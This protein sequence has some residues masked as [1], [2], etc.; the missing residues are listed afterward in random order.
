MNEITMKRIEER[1]ET[2]LE[3]G[4][5]TKC[6]RCD[7]NNAEIIKT[8]HYFILD[9]EKCNFS[10]GNVRENN[11]IEKIK[12]AMEISNKVSRKILKERESMVNL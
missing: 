8:E 7:N 1:K 4:I 9:C 2:I 12:I 10:M 11:E 5:K 6:P 3:R